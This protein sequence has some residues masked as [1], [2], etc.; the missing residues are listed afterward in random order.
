MKT[1][2]ALMG[3][4]LLLQL[5]NMIRLLNTSCRHSVLKNLTKDRPRFVVAVHLRVYFIRI[6]KPEGKK[7]M[8]DT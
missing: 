1:E 7:K 3:F 5:I 4:T 6:G 8:W 2:Q